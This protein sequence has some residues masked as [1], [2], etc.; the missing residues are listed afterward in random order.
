MKVSPR[1]VINLIRQR[2]LRIPPLPTLLLVS[3]SSPPSFPIPPLPP[4]QVSMESVIKLL[5]F[6]GVG[7]EDPNQFWFM[8]KAIW[9]AQGVTDDN[10]KKEMLVRTL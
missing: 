8:I 6:K 3:P 1:S 5:V 2:I 7:S 4:P 10:I 9:E